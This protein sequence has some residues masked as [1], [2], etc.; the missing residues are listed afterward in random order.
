M[1]IANRILEF[2]IVVSIPSYHSCEV[3]IQ[4]CAMT[5]N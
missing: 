2:R 5:D 3:K 1:V 4:N